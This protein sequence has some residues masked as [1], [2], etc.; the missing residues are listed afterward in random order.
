MT[1]DDWLRHRRRNEIALWIAFFAVQTAANVAVIA[2]DL[3]RTGMDY[4]LWAVAVAEASSAAML[5]A[6]IP[7]ML[8][9]DRRFP[10]ERGRLLRHALAHL[11]FTVPWSLLHVGGM[12]ALREV[13][14]ALVGRD[15]A[16]GPWWRELPYEY[17]KDVRVYF[18]LL[19]LIYLYRFV[20]RRLRGE[21]KFVPEREAPGDRP[22]DRFL[23]KM[24]G[25]EFLVRVDDID[26]I[27]AAGNYVS[28]HVGDRCYMLRETMTAIDKRLR[29]HGFARV[30]RSAIVNLDRVDYLEPF[31]T[32]DA[33]AHLLS[34]RTV[35]V[36]RSYRQEL[37]E[38][39]A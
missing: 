33:R 9:F 30:H 19:A 10:L 24:L 2:F 16:F 4:P 8:V 5:L 20:I 35:T 25:K 11:A 15:Y 17:L 7:I 13:A 34:G 6:L 39:L 32:G 23:V 22:P 27:E 18:A 29:P 12:V 21:A 36:S 1:L 31:D 28:L 37:K 26:W 38:K 3:K 14:F